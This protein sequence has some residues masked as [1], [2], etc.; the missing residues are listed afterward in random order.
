MC[1]VFALW[2]VR[3]SWL[4]VAPGSPS[5]FVLTLVLAVAVPAGAVHLFPLFPGDPGGDCAQKLDPAPGTSAGQVGV[6]YEEEL[7]LP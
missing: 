6:S 5:L 4:S 7:R 1:V 2:E 3:Q